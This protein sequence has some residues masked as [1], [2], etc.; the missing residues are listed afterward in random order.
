MSDGIHFIQAML[1][2]Q[3]NSMVHD[4]TIRKHTVVVIEKLSCNNVQEKRYAS[5]LLVINVL[6]IS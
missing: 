1:A 3:L 4:E 5:R 6:M 2:T